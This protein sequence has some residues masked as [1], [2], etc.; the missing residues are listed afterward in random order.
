MAS[1]CREPDVL[2]L[3]VTKLKSSSLVRIKRLFLRLRLTNQVRP[4]GFV[5]K[6]ASDFIGLSHGLLYK[7][8][9]HLQYAISAKVQ[10]W[11]NT[12]FIWLFTL[13]RV[14]SYPTN[15]SVRSSMNESFSSCLFTFEFRPSVRY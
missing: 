12:V 10:I 15:E 11:Q 6:R 9:F 2:S 14:L 3:A 8:V 1:E 5:L 7:I 13:E 4:D